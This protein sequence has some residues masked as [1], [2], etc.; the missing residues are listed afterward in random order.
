MDVLEQVGTI[1]DEKAKHTLAVGTIYR[2]LGREYGHLTR[3]HNRAV[4]EGDWEA[5]HNHLAK[6]WDIYQ[7][8]S[9]LLDELIPE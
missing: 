5:A 3:L 7:E 6:M 4:R 1:A 9:L 8:R 2:K